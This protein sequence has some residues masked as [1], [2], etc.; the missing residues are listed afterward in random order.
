MAAPNALP[1]RAAI[2]VCV[3]LLAAGA[4]VYG[5]RIE[6]ST[7]VK[8]PTVSEP[9]RTVLSAAQKPV[10]TPGD[11]DITQLRS[12]ALTLPVQG[13]DAARLTDTYTQARAA[14]AAHE[15]LDIMAERGTPVLAVEDGEAVKLF[16]SKPGGITLY[17]FDPG[18]QYAYYYAHLDRYAEGLHEGSKLR[19]GQ[20]I[21][22]VGSTGNAL[23]G[24]PHLHFAIFT[25][26]PERQWWR[27][28][29]LNPFLVWRDP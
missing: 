25:L 13:V 20:V 24:A 29:P 28:K 18:R 4:V 12:R 21:G 22:Y 10:S 26:G 2:A 27:G 11:P 5:K 17:Q 23:P 1:R 3:L 16:L 9:A 7:Q 14:G 6:T 8:M 19:K 15:A